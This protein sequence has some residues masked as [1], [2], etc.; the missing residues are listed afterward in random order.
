MAKVQIKSE[1]LTPFG[2]I[3]SL[4]DTAFS[5]TIGL[6]IQKCCYF[7]ASIQEIF[8]HV[9]DFLSDFIVWK[10]NSKNL[11]SIFLSIK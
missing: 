8:L 9:Y 3:F 5:F 6:A 7:I 1:K 10:Y 11:L 4:M 2:G